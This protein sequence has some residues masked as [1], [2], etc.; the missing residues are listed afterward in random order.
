MSLVLF[1]RY[2][3]VYFP[4]IGVSF[5]GSYEYFDEIKIPIMIKA[6]ITRSNEPNANEAEVKIYNLRQDTSSRLH[7][8][9][10]Q[11][12]VEIGYKDPRYGETVGFIFKGRTRLVEAKQVGTDW[13]T[14]IKCG[15]GDRALKYARVNKVL[16]KGKN[17]SRDKAIEASNE[18]KV[19]GVEVSPDIFDILGKTKNRATTLHKSARQVL[20]EVCRDEDCIWQINDGILEIHN[21]NDFALD[22]ATVI[23]QQTGMIGSPDLNEDGITV[24]SLAVPLFREG[25][26]VDIQ[27]NKTK[28]TGGFSNGLHRVEKI[29]FDVSL[30][31]NEPF[32]ASLTCRKIEDNKVKRSKYRGIGALS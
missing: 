16:S 29:T 5:G 23:S 30:N 1:N 22:T 32:T 21:R 7:V 27:T 20:D 11:V 6:S 12:E 19:Y 4:E 24:Q 10:T 31:A 9:D 17:S 25:R 3:K 13:I 18:M 26:T 15:D 8:E 2:I 28:S 14:T